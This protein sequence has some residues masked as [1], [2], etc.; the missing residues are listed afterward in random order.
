MAKVLNMFREFS[1]ES[2]SGY[3]GLT[4]GQKNLF[5][6]TYK[7][8]LASMELE[9]RKDY[10]ENHI[11]KIVPEISIVKVYFANGERYIYMEES[12]ENKWLKIP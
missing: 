1:M 5:D 2:V 7:R 9:A 10:S 4:E 6:A 8:H 12:K 3:S 11:V